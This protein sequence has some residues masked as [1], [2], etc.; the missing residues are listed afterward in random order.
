MAFSMDEVATAANADQCHL[1][2]PK[3]KKTLWLARNM[4]R[5]NS[6]VQQNCSVKEPQ[7]ARCIKL[8]VHT[9]T[10]TYKYTEAFCP[11]DFIKLFIHLILFDD[12]DH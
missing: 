7:R 9:K 4:N 10:E 3:N 11:S 6:Y 12:L 1:F 2:H 8:C 5:I